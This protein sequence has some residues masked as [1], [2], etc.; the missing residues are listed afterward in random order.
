MSQAAYSDPASAAA[1]AERVI[2]QA[3]AARGWSDEDLSTALDS[4]STA[5]D[6][7]D[8][9]WTP[10]FLGLDSAGDF[11]GTLREL[12]AWWGFDGA[13]ELRAWIDAAIATAQAEAE[14]AE[15]TSTLAALSGTVT[16]SASDVAGVAVAA[17]EAVS[18]P[19]FWPVVGILGSLAVGVALRR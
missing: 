4:V 15:A 16:A 11:W 14:E 6:S 17:R 19:W 2:R 5:L 18:S 12:A 9:W 10:D 3:A 13:D 8:A 1:E 7:A